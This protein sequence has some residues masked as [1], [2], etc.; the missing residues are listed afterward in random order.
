MPFGDSEQLGDAI[1]EILGTD[2]L[3]YSLRRRAYDYGRSR[4]WPK[5][6][7]SYWK[8]FSA[9]GL[10]IRVAAR[11]VPSVTEA[12]SSIEVTRPTTML[13]R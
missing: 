5:V 11:A 1:I 9:K 7:Q 13:G 10:P 8:L 4:T 6:G 12:V 2:S 3:F